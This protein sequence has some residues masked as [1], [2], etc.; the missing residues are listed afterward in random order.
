M[1]S[2]ELEPCCMNCIGEYVCKWPKEM[3]C[4]EWKPD[5]DWKRKVAEAAGFGSSTKK[6]HPKMS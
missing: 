3:C 4:E 1:L 2:D 6:G 5:M